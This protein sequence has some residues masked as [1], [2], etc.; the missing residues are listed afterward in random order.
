MKFLSPLDV[1]LFLI[2][3]EEDFDLQECE[4]SFEPTNEQMGLFIK[5]RKALTGIIKNHR[6][7][8]NSKASWR[9]NRHQ[10]MKGIKAYH[11]SLEGKRFHRKLGNFL[12]TRIT[13]HDTG[14]SS[15]QRANEGYESLKALNSAKTHLYIELEY[16][17]QIYEQIELEDLALNYAY[18]LF[19]SIE[20]KMLN[21]T[22]LN[23][24][25]LVFLLDIVE[26]GALI[27]SFSE[28]SGK[29]ILSWS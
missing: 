26:T 2:E 9:K 27:A 25:E 8:Q 13:N 1:Q 11:R 12:A 7:S 4:T 15:L 22:K 29:S 3:I 17:H 24:S 16:Y 6:Q 18:K 14:R 23:E 28:K 19:R 20:T 5:K 10:M 21:D